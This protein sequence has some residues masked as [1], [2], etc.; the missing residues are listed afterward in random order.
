VKPA[1]T[2]CSGASTQ[3]N[4]GGRWLKFAFAAA[5]AGLAMTLS[6]AVNLTPP[7][8]VAR[9]ITHGALIVLNLACF[10]LLGG[11]VLRGAWDALRQGRIVTDQLF[12]AG[13]AGAFGASLLST[14]RGRGDIYYEVVV[15]LL[16]IHALGRLL[17]ERQR[18][19]ATKTLD[20]WRTTL[21]SCKVVLA[22]GTTK[23]V[24]VGCTQPGDVIRVLPGETAPLDGIVK[25][26]RA[27]VMETAHSGE[28]LPA[29]RYP[30]ER[31]LAGSVVLDGPLDL[32][33]TTPGASRELDRLAAAVATLNLEK[34]QIE[35]IA[36]RAVRIFLPSII[37]LCLVTFV[38]WWR[39]AG[40]TSAL[41]NALAVL[42]VACPCALGIALPLAHR[43]GLQRLASL[44]LVP[45]NATVGERLAS[46][47]R[48]VFDKTG[49]LTELA[50]EAGELRFQEGE[51][52][53]LRAMIAAIQRR[54]RHPVARPFWGWSDTLRNGTML[55]SVEVLPGQGVRGTFTENG[56]RR[57]VE[58]GN[59][60]LLHTP[61]MAGEQTR[62]LYVLLDGRFVGT[63]DLEESPRPGLAQLMGELHS[64]GIKLA[65]L[66]GDIALP[67]ALRDL[68]LDVFTKLSAN[69]KAC[70]VAAWEESGEHV[71]FI[72]DG[73]NDTEAMGRATI[74]LALRDGHETARDAADGEWLTSNFTQL[75]AALHIAVETRQTLR[76]IIAFAF[77]YNTI[78]LVLAACGVLHPVAAALLMLA[79][80]L[81]VTALANMRPGNKRRPASYPAT[82]QLRP[83]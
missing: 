75:P 16:S 5:A 67:T 53:G 74:G 41:F 43:M 28:P 11:S 38:T 23:V 70:R 17:T 21:D 46:I 57:I 72:G 82:V 31:V 9:S 83:A 33:V 27:Y 12:L 51:V 26:G 10:V 1:E 71:L 66:T 54:T 58:I 20:A 48:V 32:T 68:P 50:L 49:T 76:R 69:E 65:I 77:G 63:V 44:G 39:L 22:N 80:S 61:E 34:S 78:G 60:T 2:R 6:L 19:S 30:G 15:I 52:P 18:A 14:L 62:R 36:D 7:E 47:T 40:A 35:N 79:S 81:T 3:P 24:T 37:V 55:Q 25:A 56:Q 4:A 8:G 64:S 13:M 42:L 45:R 59:A 29:A 73:L